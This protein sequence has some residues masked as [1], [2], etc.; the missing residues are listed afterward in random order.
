MVNIPEFAKAFNCKAGQ[1]M[2][3]ENVCRIW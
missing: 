1:P 3:T 2:V